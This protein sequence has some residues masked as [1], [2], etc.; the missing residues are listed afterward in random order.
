MKC[1]K[2]MQI[3]YVI[4]SGDSHYVCRSSDPDTGCGSQFRLVED[5]YIRFPHNV[6]FMNRGN[7]EFYRK[8]YL[9]LAPVEQVNK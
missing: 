8:P 5:E 6:I 2:C 4:P 3:E 1:P 7:H 9:Q